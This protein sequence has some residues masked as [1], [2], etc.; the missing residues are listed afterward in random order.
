MVVPVIILCYDLPVRLKLTIKKEKFM[1]KK[2]KD[3]K[4][5]DKFINK[6]MKALEPIGDVTCVAI[7]DKVL[8]LYKNKAMF[9]FISGSELYLRTREEN[10]EIY[11]ERCNF[12]GNKYNKLRHGFPLGSDEF[13]QAATTAYWI[14]DG[15]R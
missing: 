2:V 10:A 9:G 6:V 5:D 3:D 14:A 13:L 4:N 11:Q 12:L 15:K 7:D 1:A 8:G